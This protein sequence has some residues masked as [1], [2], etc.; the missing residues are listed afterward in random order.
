[1]QRASDHWN[2]SRP[3]ACIKILD[4]AIELRRREVFVEIVVDLHR[5]RAGTSADAFNFFQRKDAVLGGLF[6]P[7]FEPLFGLLKNVVAATKHARDVGADLH[8]MFAH[9]LA[10]QHRIVR[11]SFFDLDSAKFESVSNFRDHFI[12]DKA[13]FVLRVHHHRYQGAAF[14][15]I[16][17]LQSFEPRRELWR[18]LHR[19]FTVPASFN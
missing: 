13:K 6:V 14:D 12:T 11:E 7:D 8:V 16:R 10:A 19:Y 4:D 18:N 15:G 17:V 3:L 2:R 5:R 9:G 1:M